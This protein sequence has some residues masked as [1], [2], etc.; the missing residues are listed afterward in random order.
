MVLV[1]VAFLGGGMASV[2]WRRDPTPLLHRYQNLPALPMKK[3][4]GVT[5]GLRIQKSKGKP[6]TLPSGS[7]SAECRTLGG[8]GGVSPKKCREVLLRARCTG[9]FVAQVLCVTGLGSSAMHFF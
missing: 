4:E 6:G 7:S 9:M 8:D 3:A 2:R 5:I 1:R